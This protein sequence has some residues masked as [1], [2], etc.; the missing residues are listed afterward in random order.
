MHH[1]THLAQTATLSSAPQP[2][3][4][5]F[6]CRKH[7][8]RGLKEQNDGKESQNTASNWP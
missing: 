7:N 4:L 8:P 3:T 6:C 5:S 2:K 1:A